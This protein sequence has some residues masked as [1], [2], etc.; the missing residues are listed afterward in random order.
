MPRSAEA[1]STEPYVVEDRELITGQN[2]RSDHPIAAKLIA[3]LDRA[4]VAA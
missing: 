1:P 3:A 4:T 2:P